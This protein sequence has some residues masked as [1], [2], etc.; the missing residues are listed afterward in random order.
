MNTQN[1]AIRR[2][3][4]I[5]GKEY[6]RIYIFVDPEQADKDFQAFIER[7]KRKPTAQEV[8]KNLL[9]SKNPMERQKGNNIINS[10]S[11]K[12]YRRLFTEYSYTKNS[13]S[14]IN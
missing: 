1:K 13:K 12:S 9:Q 11:L 7:M 3:Q 14:C 8:L 4:T 5:N 2:T 10:L 6:T